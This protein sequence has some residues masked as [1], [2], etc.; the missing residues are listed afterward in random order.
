LANPQNHDVVFHQKNRTPPHAG[1]ARYR[2]LRGRFLP[3]AEHNAPI[4]LAPFEPA[5]DVINTF[6][7]QCLN[8]RLYFALCGKRKRFF[9]VQASANDGAPYRVAVQNYVEN[10]NR[11]LPG[12][13]TIE[14]ASPTATK[15]ADGLLERDQ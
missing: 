10:R 8:R 12:R 14:H 1:L 11:K 13:K 3:D 5:E 7:W 9:K 6:Q 2:C 4:Y 15:H